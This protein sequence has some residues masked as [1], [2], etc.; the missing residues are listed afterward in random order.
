MAE[1]LDNAAGITTSTGVSTSG[2]VVSNSIDQYGPIIGAAT[3]GATYPYYIKYVDVADGADYETGQ[4]TWDAGTAT[5]T[6]TSV[7]TSSNGGN[8]VNWGPG[9]K[10][11][12]I[13]ADSALSTD[14]EQMVN[15]ATKLYLTTAQAANIAASKTKTDLITVTQAVDLDQMEADI[16]AFASGMTYKGNW[17]AS[18]GTFPGGGTAQIG[19][20]YYVNVSGT[21][22]AVS[23]TAGD[24]IVALT[25]NASIST[26]AGNWSKHDQTDAVQSVAGLVG[27][28]TEE[29]LRDAIHIVDLWDDKPA[30]EPIVIVF[31]GQSN[32]TGTY[33]DATLTNNA[34]VFDWEPTTTPQVGPFLFRAVDVDRASGYTGGVFTGMIGGANAITPGTATGNIGYTCAD[35]LQRTT[36]R[37]V[38][39]IT[40]HYSG[41]PISRWL[42]GGAC[43]VELSTQV[44]AALA[45]VPSGPAAPDF[46]IWMQ[47]ESNF[48]N[49]TPTDYTDDWLTVKASFESD[50]AVENVT[51][52]LVCGLPDIYEENSGYW[53]GLDLVMQ[54]T[55]E[56]VNYVNSIGAAD[57]LDF[58]GHFTGPG[59]TDMG[60]RAAGVVLGQIPGRQLYNR[61]AYNLAWRLAGGAYTDVPDGA[62]AIGFKFNTPNYANAGAKLFEIQK[63]GTAVMSVYQNGLTLMTGEIITPT[64]SSNFPS[65]F[66]AF[67]NNIGL[68]AGKYIL[69][70]MANTSNEEGFTIR[71]EASG[72]P[73]TA[74]GAKPFVI[75]N[76]GTT[77]FGIDKD[78]YLGRTTVLAP[79]TTHVATPP[80]TVTVT[81]TETLDYVAPVIASGLKLTST[82]VFDQG[83]AGDTGS[84]VN[85][86]NTFRNTAGVTNNFNGPNAIKTSNTFLADGADQDS[87]AI[88]DIVSAPNF[89]VSGAVTY[90][91]TLLYNFVASGGAVPSSTEVTYRNGFSA[92]NMTLSG[93][94]AVIGQAGFSSV[95]TTAGATNNTHVL[96]GT[97][98]VPTG[99]YA[100]YQ[101]DTL[102]N[103]WNGGFQMPYRTRNGS[104]TLTSADYVVRFITTSGVTCTFPACTSNPKLILV[105]RNDTGGNITLATTGGDTFLGGGGTTMS[106]ATSR[107][108]QSDGTS[109]WVMIAQTTT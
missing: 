24:N 46:V 85:I 16:A 47:G 1:Y 77:V 108:Y 81:G 28:I 59:L 32:C 109:Q 31:T 101:S 40:V 41:E 104:Q 64:F 96:L 95:I 75:S 7:S 48:T 100:I 72:G 35:I 44:N 71:V 80:A 54:S 22:D 4:G 92:G 61:D 14:M 25:N 18:V 26:F 39:M 102:V 11:V 103:R 70:N 9:Q 17:D 34:R 56:Y 87:I 43:Q 74:T 73:V 5:L 33:P 3:D 84:V 53:G 79:T 62:T 90:Q 6:S 52:W 50:W 93:S 76:D 88:S 55:N 65:N 8:A 78:G 23:F 51:R 107:T 49:T 2:L 68:Q 99:Q 45:A 19:D 97:A 83:N 60:Q 12:F 38:Y 57:I 82:F 69:Q 29:Q 89:A 20:F 36:G 66:A 13:T 86:A 94:G 91:T 37:D 21:V 105:V 15:G 27:T 63:N 10:A 30:G 67:T 58:A 42:P 106:N 98:A